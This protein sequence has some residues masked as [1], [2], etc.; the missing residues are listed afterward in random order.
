MSLMDLQDVRL[1][2][3]WKRALAALSVA[4]L[5]GGMAVQ[6]TLHDFSPLSAGLGAM[7][8]LGVMLFVEVLAVPRHRIDSEN[9]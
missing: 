3:H 4:F 5:V 7:V 6:P 8:L 1:K 2:R 9:R